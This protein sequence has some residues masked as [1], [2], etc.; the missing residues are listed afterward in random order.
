MPE[1]NSKQEAQVVANGK[2][3][4]PQGGG[5]AMWRRNFIAPAGGLAVN[6][7]I[8]FGT[9]IPGIMFNPAL[10]KVHWSVGTTNADLDLGHTGFSNIDGAGVVTN[11]ALDVDEFIDAGDLASA[12]LAGVAMLNARVGGIYV[13]NKNV[14][15]AKVDGLVVKGLVLVAGMPAGQEIVVE[16]PIW[17]A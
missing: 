17:T 8:I 4:L 13:S 10:A 3:N 14:L 12:T 1:F 7:T 15:G 9:I 6:D 11:V 2:F 5:K 16:I